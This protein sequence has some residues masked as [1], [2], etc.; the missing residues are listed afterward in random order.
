MDPA[1]G[2]LRVNYFQNLEHLKKMRLLDTSYLS[3]STELSSIVIFISQ[4]GEMRMIT[5]F[6]KD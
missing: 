4:F 3:N 2:C 1:L 5:T 6:A